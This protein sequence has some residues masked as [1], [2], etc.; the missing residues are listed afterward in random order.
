MNFYIDIGKL[1]LLASFV[2]L[3]VP[4]IVALLFRRTISEVDANWLTHLITLGALS[5]V[6]AAAGISGGMSRAPAVGDIIPAFLGL[7][8]G[9]SM[10]LFSANTRRGTFA[11]LCSA[12]LA[13]SLVFG[14]AFA[15][16][17]R[18][19]RSDDYRELRAICADAYTDADLLG[20][21]EAFTRF[22]AKMGGL[23]EGT[24]NWS[25]P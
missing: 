19:D 13:I 10:Y 24:M 6:G 5:L 16:K 7:L 12:V 1:F 8:G 14:F 9:V 3:T 21:S 20:N 25:I 15:S 18:N 2:G 22:S 23:C 17:Y 11:S 4:F